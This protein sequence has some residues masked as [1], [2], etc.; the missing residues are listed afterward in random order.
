MRAEATGE[1]DIGS[2]GSAEA[3]AR[4]QGRA[5]QSDEWP[6]CLVICC[7]KQLLN[8]PARY[9]HPRGCS[10]DA[11]GVLREQITSRI[12][13]RVFLYQGFFPH[14]FLFR[15]FCLWYGDCLGIV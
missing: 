13:A 14:M 2:P 7:N 15:S 10:W 5:G 6:A 3:I 11:S 1:E 12:I 4:D 9:R 8:I